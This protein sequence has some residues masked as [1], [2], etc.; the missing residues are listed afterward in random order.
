[1]ETRQPI[2]EVRAIRA[3]KEVE[4]AKAMLDET[5]GTF[6]NSEDE[7]EQLPRRRPRRIGLKKVLAKGKE[8]EIALA[9]QLTSSEFLAM[10]IDYDR[11]SWQERANVHLEDQLEKEKRNIDL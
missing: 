8:Q 11:K 10:E 2:S 7:E 9:E 6:D 3:R 1:M 4:K 5:L